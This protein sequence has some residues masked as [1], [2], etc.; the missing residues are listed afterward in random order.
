MSAVAYLLVGGDFPGD[1]RSSHANLR[2]T[3][4]NRSRLDGP[5]LVHPIIS[6]NSVMREP[7]LFLKR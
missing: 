6:T 5:I 3:R 7:I 1:D 4:S 2:V